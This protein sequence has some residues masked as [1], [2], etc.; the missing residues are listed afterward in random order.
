MRLKMNKIKK[1]IELGLSQEELSTAIKSAGDER[2]IN[3]FDD[4]LQNCEL[5]APAIE[6]VNVEDLET[7]VKISNG[8]NN[9]YLFSR[10]PNLFNKSIIAI[11]GLFTFIVSVFV[12][13][14]FN[15]PN[16]KVVLVKENKIK[17]IDNSDLLVES[18]EVLSLV[19][20]EKNNTTQF[21][22]ITSEKIIKKKSETT[23][24]IDFEY[25]SIINDSIKAD[26]LTNVKPVDHF[27]KSNL[28]E[29]VKRTVIN[30]KPQRIVR[31]VLVTGMIDPKYKGDNYK[32]SNLVDFQGGDEQLQK[33][34][35][36]RLKLQIKDDDIPS[37]CST[38]VFN[39]EVTNRGKVKK[40]SV[41]SRTTPELENTIIK[42]MEGLDSWRKGSKRASK[43]YSVFVTFK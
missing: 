2:V 39:F 18:D 7:V 4:K 31:E 24:L 23:Y 14:N 40:V 43:N 35:F 26:D 21:K 32:I 8:I 9:K 33:E 22:E 34:I 6:L 3:K 37:A 36:R 20:S 13:L 19:Q 30:I 41:Q 11:V 25:D 38:I 5:S 29:P 17:T 15:N 28:K 42:T 10:F 27:V 12:F 16:P 1:H